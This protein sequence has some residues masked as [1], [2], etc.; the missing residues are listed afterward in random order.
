MEVAKFSA[1]DTKAGMEF[2][3]R[4]RRF[5]AWNRKTA[6]KTLAALMIFSA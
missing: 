6:W 5:S 1:W 2:T 4:P 3:Y